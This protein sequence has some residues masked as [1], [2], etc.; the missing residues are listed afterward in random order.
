M[1]NIYTLGESA[2]PIGRIWVHNL[3]V[4]FFKF[5][6]HASKHMNLFE[7]FEV[8][9]HGINK[10]KVDKPE[11]AYMGTCPGTSSSYDQIRFNYSDPE[12]IN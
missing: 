12:Y 6:K 8:K 7:I 1:Q 3:L 4:A 9:F 10:P 5:Y 2:T 11:N